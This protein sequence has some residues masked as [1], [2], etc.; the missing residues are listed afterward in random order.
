MACVVCRREGKEERRHDGKAAP[1]H[2]S[3]NVPDALSFCK[4]FHLHAPPAVVLRSSRKEGSRAVKTN[5]KQTKK[6]TKVEEQH[7]TQG[8]CK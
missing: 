1:N 3:G 6:Q 7:A 2:E 8:H 5:K 4:C